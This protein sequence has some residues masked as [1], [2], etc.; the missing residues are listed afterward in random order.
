MIM[1]R[2]IPFGQVAGEGIFESADGG[3]GKT[4]LAPSAAKASMVEGV[5]V[6]RMEVGL[7]EGGEEVGQ[8]SEQQVVSGRRQEEALQVRMARDFAGERD[9]ALD[10]RGRVAAVF[11]GAQLGHRAVGPPAETGLQRGRVVVEGRT[12]VGSR[13]DDDVIGFWN[14][15]GNGARGEAHNLD[16]ASVVGGRHKTCPHQRVDESRRHSGQLHR[17][18]QKGG[19]QAAGCFA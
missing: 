2:L 10:L 1:L 3:I 14:A 7:E 19:I 11:D 18:H 9:A 15:N 8:L 16:Q 17:K 6:F 5:L 12:I 4:Q 13:V